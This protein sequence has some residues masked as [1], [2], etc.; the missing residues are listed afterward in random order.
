M[1]AQIQICCHIF[2][3][4][5]KLVKTKIRIWAAIKAVFQTTFCQAMNFVYQTVF[6][7][8]KPKIE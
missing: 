3:E 4:I 2:Q 6:A 7:L 1:A 5:E 8:F